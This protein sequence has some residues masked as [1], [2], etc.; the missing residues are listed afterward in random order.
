MD[1]SAFRSFLGGQA[2]STS[3]TLRPRPATSGA[4]GGSKH[5]LGIGARDS[6]RDHG[7]GETIPPSGSVEQF[8]PRQQKLAVDKGKAKAVDEDKPAEPSYT[9]YGYADRA[10]MRRAGL[11]EK[12]AAVSQDER[13]PRGQSLMIM[14]ICSA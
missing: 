4:V 5:R 13:R 2:S 14:A 1:Q 7:I 12:A 3:S 8:R 11:E 9:R 6:R 10:S